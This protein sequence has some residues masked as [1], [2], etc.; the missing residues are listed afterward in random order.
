VGDEN[1]SRWGQESAWLRHLSRKDRN[2]LPEGVGE[3][4]ETKPAFE[5]SEDLLVEYLGKK[6]SS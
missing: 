5:A 2:G 6:R 4:S 3:A 1:L